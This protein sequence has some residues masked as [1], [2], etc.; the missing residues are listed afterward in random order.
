MCWFTNKK[1]KFKIAKENIPIYK[2][3]S[4]EDDKILSYYKKF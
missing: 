1:L 3:C 2:I 4:K